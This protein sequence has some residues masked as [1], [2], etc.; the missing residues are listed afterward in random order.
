MK[1]S[2]RVGTVTTST[3]EELPNAERCVTVDT[4]PFLTFRIVGVEIRLRRL[5][6]FECPAFTGSG[7]VFSAAFMAE[8][9]ATFTVQGIE[10][11]SEAQN[12]EDELG[13]LQG[14]MGTE[15]DHESGEAKV[16]YDVD[17]L[18]EERVK[19]TVRDMGFTVE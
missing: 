3:V 13:Q 2:V 8:N 12:I 14:V 17:L 7:V 10:S 16:R 15:I 1:Q 5:G 4:V 19:I 6:L 18:S 11:K 9:N